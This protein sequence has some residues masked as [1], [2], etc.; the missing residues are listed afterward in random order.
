MYVWKNTCTNITMGST[1][2]DGIS[3]EWHGQDVEIKY[4]PWDVSI[5]RTNRK[6]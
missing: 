2:E 4:K 6:E 5:F 1:A 3:K